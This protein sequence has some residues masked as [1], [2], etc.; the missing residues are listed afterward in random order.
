MENIIKW[1]T[2]EVQFEGSSQGNLSSRDIIIK[3]CTLDD[4]DSFFDWLRSQKSETSWELDSRPANPNFCTAEEIFEKRK[5]TTVALFFRVGAVQIR[6]FFYHPTEIELDFQASSICD[7]ETL[8]DLVYCVSELGKM[9]TK[10]VVVSFSEEPGGGDWIFL[11]QPSND[12]FRIRE[13][14][15]SMDSSQG[16]TS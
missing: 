12:V 10:E 3:N 13:N 14:G 8:N 5:T 16:S 11:Y 15:V 6:A 9:L 2:V 1:S 4:W 7:Q